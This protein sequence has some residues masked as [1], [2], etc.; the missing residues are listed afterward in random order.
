MSC[1][2]Q[3]LNNIRTEIESYHDHY[4][5]LAD[6]IEV[7]QHLFDVLKKSKGSDKGKN[8]LDISYAATIDSMM[9]TFARLYDDDGNSK[10]I[11]KLI[12]KC[13]K[14]SSL[15]TN[16]IELENSLDRF[17][18]RLCTDEDLV[19]AV[20]TIKMRRDKIFAHNDKKYFN[21]PQKDD[22]YLPIYR[23][24][25]LRDYTRELLE[26]L[27]EYFEIVFSNNIIYNKDLN[28]LIYS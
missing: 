7:N 5:Y 22:S 28:E 15:C 10:N 6:M 26:M 24:W 12:E 19:S 17:K 20:R 13:R 21:S 27:A 25:L 23:L 8:F 16:K 4:V 9:I 1:A 14:N 3:M 18:Q 11:I 2:N